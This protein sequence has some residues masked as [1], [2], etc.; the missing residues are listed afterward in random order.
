PRE[1]QLS[2]IDKIKFV[3]FTPY[4]IVSKDDL[5]KELDSIRQKGYA[6]ENRELGEFTF[7]YGVPVFDHKG[8]VIA[9]ISLSD[10]A[11]SDQDASEIVAD[12]K[13]AASEISKT[14]DYTLR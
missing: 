3:P 8:N 4:T 5:L 1:E 7:C 12:L 11:L 14:A 2:I 13:A 9:S 10:I 6:T